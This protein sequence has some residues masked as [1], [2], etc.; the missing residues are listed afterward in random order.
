MFN[1]YPG[2]EAQVDGKRFSAPIHLELRATYVHG[3][4]AL[5][6]KGL[7]PYVFGGAGIGQF[8][9]RVPVQ[10]IE[11]RPGQRPVKQE[12]DA[13]HLA[14]PAF[15]ALGAGGRYAVSQ[16]FA[17]DRRLALRIELSQPHPCCCD[18]QS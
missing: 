3:K 2:S 15:I 9:T 14:G 4:D 18:S 7:A 11:D 12:V 13:W 5:W 6:K 10:V 16:R 8:E 17:L 1:S